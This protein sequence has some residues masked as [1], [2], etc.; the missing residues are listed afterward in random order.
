MDTKHIK[1]KNV[2]KKWEQNVTNKMFLVKHD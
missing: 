1:W 2:S